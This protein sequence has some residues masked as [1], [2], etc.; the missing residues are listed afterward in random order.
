MKYEK[1]DIV[2]IEYNGAGRPFQVYTSD[3]QGYDFFFKNG[4]IQCD[5]C[6]MN[7]RP[8]MNSLTEEWQTKHRKLKVWFK[9][10]YRPKSNDGQ[11]PRILSDLEIATMG[12][13]ISVVPRYIDE[14]LEAINN[15]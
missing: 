15:R 13:V 2:F 1:E 3:L 4:Y 7:I 14:I 12:Y 8:Y 6:S 10:E 9:E 11:P 5:W